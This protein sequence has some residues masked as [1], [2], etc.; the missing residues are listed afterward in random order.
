MCIRDRP[1][2]EKKVHITRWA[3]AIAEVLTKKWDTMAERVV[4]PLQWLIDAMV[5][6][7]VG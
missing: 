1:Y 4:P 6:T 7:T 5:D 2:V 3:I